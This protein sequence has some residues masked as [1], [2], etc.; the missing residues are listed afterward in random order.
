MLV[1]IKSI[2]SFFFFLHIFFLVGAKDS[3][4]TRGKKI[5]AISACLSCAVIVER[6]LLRFFFVVSATLTQEEEKKRRIWTQENVEERQENE[7]AKKR[8]ATTVTH[9]LR[10]WLTKQSVGEYG[11]ANSGNR[12]QDGIMKKPK[13]AGRG[14]PMPYAGARC[15]F[16]Q[17]LQVKTPY[18]RGRSLPARW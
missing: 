15:Q 5:I 4:V 8:K 10:K 14:L 2:C 13:Q 9:A 11:R 17:N 12:M 16:A 1:L 7:G 18:W 3:H 6:W